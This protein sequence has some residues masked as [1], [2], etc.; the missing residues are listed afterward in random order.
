MR[1]IEMAPFV[2]GDMVPVV[3]DSVFLGPRPTRPPAYEKLMQLELTLPHAGGRGARG[4]REELELYVSQW[5]RLRSAP[6]W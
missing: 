1:P 3:L 5:R 2:D 6:G 4:P